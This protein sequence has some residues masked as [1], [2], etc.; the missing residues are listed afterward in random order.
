[1]APSGY[2]QGVDPTSRDLLNTPEATRWLLRRQDAAAW[3]QPAL[4]PGLKPDDSN[5][6]RPAADDK[7]GAGRDRG[8]GQGFGLVR[9][10]AGIADKASFGRVSVISYVNPNPLGYGRLKENAR[11]P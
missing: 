4:R 5:R 8:D 9:A 11:N 1:M 3:H 2:L 7:R 6:Y 10:D